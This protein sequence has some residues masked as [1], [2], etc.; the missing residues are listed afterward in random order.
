METIQWPALSS[1]LSQTLLTS[2]G[3]FFSPNFSIGLIE[4][5]RILPPIIPLIISDIRRIM[6]MQGFGFLVG[7]G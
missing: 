6:D 7:M 5:L 2:L 3:T 1:A 4:Q